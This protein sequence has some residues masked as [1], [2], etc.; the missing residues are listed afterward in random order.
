MIQSR[1]WRDWIISPIP[2]GIESQMLQDV[3]IQGRI[4]VLKGQKAFYL[5]GTSPGRWF[6]GIFD[7]PNKKM[8]SLCTPCLCGEKNILDKSEKRTQYA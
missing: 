2:S 5:A 3:L 6:T 1:L 4:C 8:F 7:P